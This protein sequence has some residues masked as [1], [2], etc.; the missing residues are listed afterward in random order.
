MR[1]NCDLH[2]VIDEQNSANWEVILHNCRESFSGT[3]LRSI[4]IR[5]S[6]TTSAVVYKGQ[7][8]LRAP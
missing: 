2:A 6:A 8:R 3:F 5:F 7:L 1:K 4:R